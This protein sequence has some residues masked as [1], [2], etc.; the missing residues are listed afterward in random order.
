[1]PS[2][3]PNGKMG[4]MRSEPATDIAAR[5]DLVIQMRAMLANLRLEVRSNT[6]ATALLELLTKID[7][8]AA[9]ILRREAK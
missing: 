6:S 8:L 9:E 5:Q 4:G 3:R 1:M 2:E 7:D